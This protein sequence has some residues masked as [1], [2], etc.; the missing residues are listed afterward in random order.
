[1]SHSKNL[2]FHCI[3]NRFVAN[4]NHS[5]PPAYSDHQTKHIYDKPCFRAP[6]ATLSFGSTHGCDDV[7]LFALPLSACQSILPI[8]P[9]D[10]FMASPLNAQAAAGRGSIMN[11]WWIESESDWESGDLDSCHPSQNVGRRWQLGCNGGAVEVCTCFPHGR[12]SLSQF[13]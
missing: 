12:G 7:L 13:S 6:M 10:N 11:T 1:M 9:T 8:K 2:N 4:N 5:I 3:L